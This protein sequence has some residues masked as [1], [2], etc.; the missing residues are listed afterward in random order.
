MMVVDFKQLWSTCQIDSER[1]REV[2][3]ICEE[4]KHNKD[5][6]AQV[7]LRT[8][9]PS[10]LIAALHYRESSLR[11]DCVLHNGQKIIGTGKK[12]SW[13]PKGRGPFETWEESAV[14]ALDF[15]QLT[16]F[17]NWEIDRVLDRAERYNGLGY[18]KRNVLSPYVWAGTNHSDEKGKYVSDG[19]YSPTADEK[20]LGVAALLIGLGVSGRIKP[21]T[22]ETQDLVL[23]RSEALQTAEA[24]ERLAKV[25]RE[26]W[27]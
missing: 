16:S 7:A 27:S 19:R 11:F 25:F 15:D 12:T 3:D 18:R 5:R 2:N 6:Y 17:K 24:I 8:G 10:W 1:A 14:D 20:Q 4:I 23:M 13:V 21:V 22:K 26:K 9:V